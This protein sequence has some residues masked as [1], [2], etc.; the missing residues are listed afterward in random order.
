MSFYEQPLPIADLTIEKEFWPYKRI[1]TLAQLVKA[2]SLPVVIISFYDT[3]CHFCK[4]LSS[5]AY[6]L[7]EKYPDVNFYFCNSKKAIEYKKNGNLKH[8]VIETFE[9]YPQT[10]IF[11]N[12]NSGNYITGLVD[13]KTLEKLF[14]EAQNMISNKTVRFAVLRSDL[15]TFTARDPDAIVVRANSASDPVVQMA[16]LQNK[17]TIVAMFY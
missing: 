17:P 7:S 5:I 13:S 3:T 2:M 11:K 15:G 9:A 14:M 16:T 12:S 8:S 10:Y 1:E 6:Q 4:Q